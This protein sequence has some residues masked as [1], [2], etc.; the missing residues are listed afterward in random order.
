MRFEIPFRPTSCYLVA[1]LL[2]TAMLAPAQNTGWRR[3]NSAAAA[4]QSAGDPATP[5]ARDDA[6]NPPPAATPNAAFAPTVPP[7]PL[8]NAALPSRL[9]L[10]PGTFLT[11]RINQPLSSNHNQQGDFFSGTLAEPVVIDG[12]VVAQRGQSVAGRVT[13]VDKGG[14]LKGV[15][16][17]GIEITSLTA[18]DGQQFPVQTLLVTRA[19]HSNAGRDVATVGTTTAIGAVIGSAADWGRGAA[20][21]AGAGA[22]AGLVGVLLSPGAPAVIYPES[23]LTFR[24]QA[25]TTISTDRAPQAFRYVD[26]SDYQQPQIVQSQMQPPP[27]PAPYYAPYGYAS[28]YP[29]PYP[30]AYSYPYPYYWGPSF[31][32]VIGPRWGWGYR[33]WRR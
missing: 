29:Y 32:V 26:P 3:L 18:V 28:P 25:A 13:A 21:G 4:D 14:H 20:I 30:Y 22:F 6:D 12:V 19:G 8:P 23:L 1:G 7:A 27:R 9:T 33:G 16:K 31:G 24:V 2:L 15:S 5:V 11:V 17:L 10:Q